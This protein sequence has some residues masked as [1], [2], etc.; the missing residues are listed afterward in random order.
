MYFRNIGIATVTYSFCSEKGL[1]FS[2]LDKNSNVIWEYWD[3]NHNLFIVFTE[4]PFFR[5]WRRIPIYMYFE[6]IGITT[7][8]YSFCSEKD[9]FFLV[10]DKTSIIRLDI[11]QKIYTTGFSGKKNL[12][13]KSA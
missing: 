11:C 5:F 8:T 1:F 3:H 6:N 9:I 7:I 12:L 2:P 4:G 13:T 10:L